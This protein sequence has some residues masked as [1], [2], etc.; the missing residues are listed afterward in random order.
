VAEII[1]ADWMKP[2][3]RTLRGEARKSVELEAIAPAMFAIIISRYL[4]TIEGLLKKG[5]DPL[6][7]REAANIVAGKSPP[8]IQKVMF[9]DDEMEAAEWHGP[10]AD[11]KAL[12][13]RHAALMERARFNE[14]LSS[15]L[16]PVLLDCSP[17]DDVWWGNGPT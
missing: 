2:L 6:S 10:R 7:V 3:L 13:L 11:I 4:D 15:E 8:I 12:A 5:A 9:T 17:F 1:W 14:C 16:L